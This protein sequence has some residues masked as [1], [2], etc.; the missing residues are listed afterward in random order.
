LGL[1]VGAT[2]RLEISFVKTELKT[3]EMGAGEMA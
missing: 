3:G 2:T 1:K